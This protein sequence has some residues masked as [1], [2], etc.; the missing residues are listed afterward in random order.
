MREAD[1][2]YVIHHDVDPYFL[3]EIVQQKEGHV[4]E[5]LN[6]F[7]TSRE[8]RN[9]HSSIL[10][11][12]IG[13]GSSTSPSPHSLFTEEN[14]KVQRIV[15]WDNRGDGKGRNTRLFK[16][17]S[18]YAYPLG[19]G[20]TLGLLLEKGRELNVEGLPYVEV[21][22]TAR[23]VYRFMQ[24]KFRGEKK[25]D[26]EREVQGRFAANA[27]WGYHNRIVG[28][29]LAEAATRFDVSYSTIK[30]WKASGKIAL[31]KKVWEVQDALDVEAQQVV[32]G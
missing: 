1:Y 14:G 31:I 22:S 7:L 13:I 18:S 29:T 16:R 19:A 15:I 23:S 27:R 28:E 5:P 12:D 2:H 10:Y 21:N 30:R 9:N 26:Q 17:I 8:Q 20:V 24:T 11:P 3:G 6:H 32:L 25:T 4:I